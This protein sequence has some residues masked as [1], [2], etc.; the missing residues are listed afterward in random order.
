MMYGPNKN[1]TTDLAKL[2]TSSADIYRFMS[3]TSK[4]TDLVLINSF[5]SWVDV[6]DV[7]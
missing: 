6:C 7:A 1:A 4:S 5:W 3:P 2:N